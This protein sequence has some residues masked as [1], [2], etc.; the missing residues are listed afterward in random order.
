[1]CFVAYSDRHHMVGCITK[2]H[3]PPPRPLR[4]TYIE[5]WEIVPKMCLN[6]GLKN[7]SATFLFILVVSLMVL[8][9]N[10]TRQRAIKEDHVPYIN[11]DP[12]KQTYKHN[13]VKNK[14]LRIKCFF[15]L[16]ILDIKGP[17]AFP[18][19][20]ADGSDLHLDIKLL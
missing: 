10:I 6:V 19:H 17:F 4:V 5:T 7:R 9:V 14:Y 13:M 1:M 20:L 3:I 12:R 16:S 18:K 2:L 11:S 15:C 8:V